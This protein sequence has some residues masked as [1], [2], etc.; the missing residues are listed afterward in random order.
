MEILVCV[1]PD[2]GSQNANYAARPKGG[3]VIAIQPDGWTWGTDE[4]GSPCFA[5]LRL[6]GVPMND[7]AKLLERAE[8]GYGQTRWYRKHYIDLKALSFQPKSGMTLTKDQIK[9]FL[10][11]VQA[12]D[13]RMVEVK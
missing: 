4:L 7:L 11:A 13:N 1:I 2:Q 10:A 5:M 8:D 9:S 6:P 3:D 12:R